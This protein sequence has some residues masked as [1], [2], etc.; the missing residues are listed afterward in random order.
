[1]ILLYSMEAVSQT[2]CGIADIKGCNF[3]KIFHILTFKLIKGVCFVL[4]AMLCRNVWGRNS[5]PTDAVLPFGVI[6]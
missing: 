2:I 6:E 3:H 4:A 5:W 1:M